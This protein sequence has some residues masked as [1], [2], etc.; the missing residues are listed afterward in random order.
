MFSSWRASLETGLGQGLRA[1]RRQ[2]TEAAVQADQL[3]A[4]T[5][6]A[7]VASYGDG[8]LADELAAAAGAAYQGY[9][10]IARYLRQDYA[11][12]A[13]EADGVGAQRYAV[14]ARLSL[15][16]DIDLT[17]AYEW[18]WAELGRIE[19]EMAAEAGKV[20]PGASV[21]EAAAI[22]DDSQY[23]AGT[24]AYLTWLQHRHDQAIAQLD[25]VHFDIA[26]PLRAIEVVLARGST[27]GAAYYTP[28]SEDLTRTGRAGLEDCAQQ[29]YRQ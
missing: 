27:S 6:D 22:L 9:R 20:S 25:G 4:G 26:T 19:A 10:E 21:D 28:P 12:R 8:P 11:P 29:P 16:A 2:A 1:A 3:A 13:A 23:V 5:H 17:E 15:G 18:G 7:L 14:A 24:D